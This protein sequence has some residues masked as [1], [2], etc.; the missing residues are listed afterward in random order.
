ML[1]R[2]VVVLTVLAAS[3]MPASAQA[4]SSPPDAMAIVQDLTA[5]VQAA[6]EKQDVAGWASVTAPDVTIL[7]ASNPLTSGGIIHGRADAEKVYAGMFQQGMK[8]ATIKV[9]EAHFIGRSA[10]WWAGTIHFSGAREIDARI[11]Q[12]LVRSKGAWRARLV[13]LSGDPPHAG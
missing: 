13:V 4:K 8:H 6:I 9:L 11:A 5:T 1:P 3:I 2:F 7:P 10:I 12:V